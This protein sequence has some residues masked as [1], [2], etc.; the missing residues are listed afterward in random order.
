MRGGIQV[1]GRDRWSQGIPH[2]LAPANQNPWAWKSCAVG[3]TLP[4][5]AADTANVSGVLVD[6][7]F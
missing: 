6:R 1:L 2:P 3:A 4:P 5:E 7:V